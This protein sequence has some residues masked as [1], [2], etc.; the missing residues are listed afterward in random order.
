MKS[1]LR[2]FIV[3]SILIMTISACGGGGGASK[4]VEGLKVGIEA[5]PAWTQLAVYVNL[6]KALS[7]PLISDLLNRKGEFKEMTAELKDAGI[8]IKKDLGQLVFGVAEINAFKKGTEPDFMA[9]ITGNYDEAKLTSFLKKKAKDKEGKELVVEKIS[10]FTVLYDKAKPD[11]IKVAFLKG[12][13]VVISTGTKIKEALDLVQGKGNP[14]KGTDKFYSI[15]KPLSKYNLFWSAITLNQATK[16]MG[17]M[18]GQ[19]PMLAGLTKYLD[20]IDGITIASGVSGSDYQLSLA[21]IAQDSKSADEIKKTLDGLLVLGK[22][23]SQKAP[24]IIKDVINK[25]KVIHSGK[26]AGISLSLTKDELKKLSAMA[27]K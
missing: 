16:Q 6:N 24:P 22:G 5:L 15:V 25:I 2:N 13:V 9:I 23:F 17:K 4:S 26:S 3:I 19:N 11:K 20:K 10:G 21:S 7:D 12:K 1:I 14:L 27:P 8:D 18:A